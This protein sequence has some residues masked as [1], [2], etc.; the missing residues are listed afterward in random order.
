MKAMGPN[1]WPIDQK[2]ALARLGRFD[3]DVEDRSLLVEDFL[4]GKF[5][6]AFAKKAHP[7]LGSVEVEELS[8]GGLIRD[9]LILGG[10]IL[11]GRGHRDR[12]ANRCKG[13]EDLG[14]LVS[15]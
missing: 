8:F 7:S 3:H 15:C 4:L 2:L 13:R 1:G 11:G 12:F 9:R 5:H 6:L 10:L 14:L